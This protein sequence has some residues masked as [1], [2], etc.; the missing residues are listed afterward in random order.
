MVTHT[1]EVNRKQ[2]EKRAAALLLKIA[3]KAKLAGGTE[4]SVRTPN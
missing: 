1:D 3:K 4:G 2:Q